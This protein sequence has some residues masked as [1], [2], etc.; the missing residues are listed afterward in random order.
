M[1]PFACDRSA[2]V[3]LRRILIQQ[4]LLATSHLT[5]ATEAVVCLTEWPPHE[6]LKR[7]IFRP[8]QRRWDFECFGLC[9]DR[10]WLVD[11]G[12]RPVI[13]GD[14]ATWRRLSDADRTFFQH[15]GRGGVRSPDW[16]TEREW[17]HRGDL[18]LSRL[19][20]THGLVFTPDRQSAARLA[21]Y[22]RWPMVCLS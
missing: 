21:R 19:P 13:Y 14:D 12:A 15:V 3:S 8:A 10:Q 5:R 17:R 20:A 4:R 7:R 16:T 18:D 1:D 6:L 2:L 9:I 11:K 22:S